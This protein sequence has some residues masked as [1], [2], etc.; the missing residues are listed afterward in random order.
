[1]T[2][3][4]SIPSCPNKPYLKSESQ[5]ALEQTTKITFH[6]FPKDPERHQ[7]WVDVIGNDQEI[8]SRSVVCSLHFQENEIDRTSSWCTKLKEGAVPCLF[9]NESY[10]VERAKM[11]QPRQC[12]IKNCP[13]SKANKAALAK[14]KF[15][16][17]PTDGKLMK[18]WKERSGLKDNQLVKSARICSNH[19]KEKDFDRIIIPGKKILKENA[20]PSINL[21]IQPSSPTRKVKKANWKSENGNTSQ[22]EISSDQLKDDTDTY[23]DDEGKNGIAPLDIFS[24][25]QSEDVKPEVNDID[26]TKEVETVK[27]EPLERHS[28]ADSI[29]E[30]LM[31]CENKE[32]MTKKKIEEI[33]DF[34]F[35]KYCD[36]LKITDLNDIR[37]KIEEDLKIITTNNGIHI[38]L[39]EISN[40]SKEI[41]DDLTKEDKNVKEVNGNEIND[42]TLS[43]E[44]N[45]AIK[46]VAEIKQEWNAE[47]QESNNEELKIKTGNDH[48][49]MISMNLENKGEN[50][51]SPG[52][53]QIKPQGK[54]NV[55]SLRVVRKNDESIIPI[56]RSLSLDEPLIKKQRLTDTIKPVI[57]SPATRDP[58]ERKKV[59][60]GTKMNPENNILAKAMREDNSLKSNGLVKSTPKPAT[61]SQQQPNV[62]QQSSGQS[63]SHSDKP[64]I[65]SEPIISLSTQLQ[66]QKQSC[67]SQTVTLHSTPQ[68]NDLF[69]PKEK[70]DAL[71]KKH[72]KLMIEKRNSEMFNSQIIESMKRTMEK[73]EKEYEYIRASRDDLEIELRRVEAGLQ[74]MLTPNQIKLLF[75]DEHVSWT[76]KELLMAFAIR[77]QSRKCYH[78]LRHKLNYPLPGISTVQNWVSSISKDQ[79]RRLINT[80]EN[81]VQS[82]EDAVEEANFDIT[83]KEATD[84]TPEVPRTESI[85]YQQHKQKDPDIIV[86]NSMQNYS[87]DRFTNILE[88][89]QERKEN[90]EYMRIVQEV[91]GDEPQEVNYTSNVVLVDEGQASN[92]YNEN[93]SGHY[94]I[95]LPDQS[96]T[97]NC[98]EQGEYQQSDNFIKGIIG[99]PFDGKNAIAVPNYTINETYSSDQTEM[100]YQIDA[101]PPIFTGNN[102][103]QPHC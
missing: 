103:E 26:L 81:S 63:V 45:K 88:G 21:N 16:R 75:G 69:V 43:Q 3:K 71:L 52:T 80:V 6:R 57:K 78:F 100:D 65:S 8:N 101:K 13:N 91:I 15:Y 4:C 77:F 38:E 7:A 50:V 53:V 85:L 62:A 33:V 89:V 99:Q 24:D 36:R 2:V 46:Q 95:T 35:Q 68:P 1:M 41:S 96:K 83:V 31:R 66:P 67:H 70:Y 39:Q 10:I 59:C 28:I 5:L 74:K 56:K 40:E 32:V 73:K 19:F 44:E 42:E 72:E 48:T 86:L 60:N 18:K 94:Y 27:S 58:F 55:V 97:Y 23:S 90:K 98:V 25:D 76:T 61:Q 93:K 34:L 11:K 92:V 20:I 29:Y 49:T 12:V 30:K 51:H 64:Q 37:L 9:I 14:I 79:C 87:T 47:K 22:G 17:F 102:D 84:E 54:V 82:N